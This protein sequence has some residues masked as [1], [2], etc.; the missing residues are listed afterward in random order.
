MAGYAAMLLGDLGADVIKVQRRGTSD[1]S[2]TWGPPFA[3]TESTYCRLLTATTFAHAGHKFSARPGNFAPA[4][5]ARR[6]LSAQPAGLES[7]TKRAA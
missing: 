1:P 4:D 5:W 3:R 6:R 7:V 2:R